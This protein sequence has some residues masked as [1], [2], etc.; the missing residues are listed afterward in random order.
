MK[1]TKECRTTTNSREYHIR[2]TALDLYDESD[3]FRC[4]MVTRGYVGYW[5]KK[6]VFP[7]EKRQWRTWKHNRRTQWKQF[8][9]N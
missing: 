6:G 7:S 2:M 8:K 9:S 1:R 4:N 5:K 3:R